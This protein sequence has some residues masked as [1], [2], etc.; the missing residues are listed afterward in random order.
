M[1][2]LFSGNDLKME[3]STAAQAQHVL[4]CMDGLKNEWA[5]SGVDI[6]YVDA[7]PHSFHLV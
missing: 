2:L 7:V 1:L 5:R 6:V 4:D 3:G